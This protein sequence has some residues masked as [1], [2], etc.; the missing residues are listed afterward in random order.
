MIL[1]MATD[2]VSMATETDCDHSSR[3][4]SLNLHWWLRRRDR[5]NFVEWARQIVIKIDREV[6][7]EDCK[8]MSRS[9]EQDGSWKHLGI[10]NS[11]WYAFTTPKH[12]FNMQLPPPVSVPYPNGGSVKIFVGCADYL[13]NVVAECFSLLSFICDFIHHGFTH[14][15]KR[16]VK[17]WFETYVLSI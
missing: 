16:R 4:L 11:Y 8:C 10:P 12:N 5:W 1:M 13:C 3:G 7:R 17:T 2:H 15:W 6:I 14:I 9:Q